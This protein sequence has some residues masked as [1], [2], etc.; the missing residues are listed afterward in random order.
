MSSRSRWRKP[1]RFTVTEYL[2][3]PPATTYA[4]WLAYPALL[5]EHVIVGFTAF[6]TSLAMTHVHRGTYLP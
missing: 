5:E 3:S 6:V 1:S 4:S 2:E